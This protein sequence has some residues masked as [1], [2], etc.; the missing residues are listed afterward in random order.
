MRGMW[1][2]DARGGKKTHAH[3]QYWDTK[4]GLPHQYGGKGTHTHFQYCQKKPASWELV[5]STMWSLEV[6]LGLSGL[7]AGPLTCQATSLIPE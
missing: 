4:T 2:C 6:E 1:A 3:S 5:L 7:V